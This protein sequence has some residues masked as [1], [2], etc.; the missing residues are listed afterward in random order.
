MGN[1]S[2]RNKRVIE[3][4]VKSSQEVATFI[5]QYFQEL[6]NIAISPNTCIHIRGTWEP[7]QQGE[8]KANFDVTYDRCNDLIIGSVGNY[9]I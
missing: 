2:D 5:W 8:F 7:P 9:K 4:V 6:E 1:W 3:K